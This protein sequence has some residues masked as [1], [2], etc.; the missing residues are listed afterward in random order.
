MLPARIVPSCILALMAVWVAPKGIGAVPVDEAARTVA[1]HL[2][3]SQSKGDLTLGPWLSE[4]MLTG[5]ATTGMVCA[6][7]WMG[8]PV[9]RQAAERGGRYIL[10][11]SVV[12]DDML[13]DEVYAFVR[14]SETSGN[15]NDNMWRTTLVDFFAS[16]RR[17][18]GS[19]EDFVEQ[20]FT[21]VDLSTATFYIAHYTMG[22]YYVNDPDKK[23]WRDILIRYLSRVDDKSAFPV[24]ALG[25][26]TWALAKTGPL[27][28]RTVGAY[29][30]AKCWEGVLLRDLP[31]ILL[32]HQVPQGA[33]FGGSF[34]WRFD[35]A[36]G[37]DS[38]EAGH[39]EDAIY[40]ALG[41]TAAASSDD[42]EDEVLEQA[43][44][45]VRSALLEGC[46]PDGRVYGL[47]SLEGQS[48]HAYAG[49][50]LQ[51]LWET[52]QWLASE[53]DEDEE[54]SAP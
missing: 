20:V 40:G 33:A 5:P 25:V 45:A 51:A 23:I 43:I 4:T 22:A 47:L 15:P 42:T 3:Q 46:G 26:A 10:W 29:G 9:Y 36:A 18:G 21:G 52:G 53:D 17:N 54:S 2:E 37:I 11:I 19:T 31:G 41:L 12:A 27:D 34:Y 44:V 24:M 39:T 6:Y 1:A 8:D 28:D 49:E 38:R 16:L 30:Q 48:Y 14:L 32:S 7:E 50:M 13:G 35:H